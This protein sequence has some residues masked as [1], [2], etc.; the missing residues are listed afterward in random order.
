ML[1]WS[2]GNNITFNY[3]AASELAYFNIFLHLRFACEFTICSWAKA[4]NSAT[5]QSMTYFE[6][7]NIEAELQNRIA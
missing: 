3:S 1:W 6:F 4:V 5:R 7:N 2:S